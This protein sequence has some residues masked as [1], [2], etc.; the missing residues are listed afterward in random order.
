MKLH[1]SA[2]CED[3]SVATVDAVAGTPCDIIGVHLVYSWEHTLAAFEMLKRIA[4]RKDVPI[5]AYGFY[6]TF[7]AEHLMR[8]YPFIDG[9]IRGEPEETF[10]EV[11]LH[12]ESGN[13]DFSRIK[14][15]VWRWGEECAVNP[16]REVI[17]DLDTL[18]FPHRTR[19]G[20]ARSGCNI[21]GS[22]GCYGI[23]SFCCIN[24]F[25]GKN[26]L[27][28]GRSP[29]NIHAEVQALFP[30]PAGKYLYF[31]DANFFGPGEAGQERAEAIAECLAGEK[32]L[33]FGL[34]CRANDV[35]ER[36]ASRLARAGLRNVFLGIESG[37]QCCLDRMNKKT[38]VEQNAAAIALLRRHG[39]EPH[40]GFIMFEPDATVAELRENFSFLRSHDLLG[41]LTATVDL[42]YHPGIALM[43]TR[44]YDRLRKDGR[45]D[46]LAGGPYH[47]NYRFKDSRV[48][49][50]ADIFGAVC[51]HLLTSM[52]QS[53]SPIYW[54]HLYAREA[55]HPS[56]GAAEELNR[57]LISLFEEVL[58]R[59]ETD[60][61]VR[62]YQQQERCVR[63]SIAC[64]DRIL[65]G[66]CRPC[67]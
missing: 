51:G 12:T 13:N 56:L 27:W 23:C 42:L 57:W 5:I 32:G 17:S 41:R 64:I 46:T 36:S 3:D 37:S 52:Q 16:R 50:C 4:A 15:L 29:G 58:Q 39:I 63:E 53:D 62:D 47:G 54:Q 25:Y 49:I 19:D 65:A 40:I 2:V 28:R 38:T 43:G 60:G 30:L 45:L 31:V 10:L 35:Q 6:P 66:A 20:I 18:P 24:N 22:R 7:A 33:A 8:T 34:E 21:L 61:S 44:M 26:P 11:C 59:L 48:Q 1:E 14:G 9:V 67:V 55:G